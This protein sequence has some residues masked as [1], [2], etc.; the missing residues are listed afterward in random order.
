[1]FRIITSLPA[2]IIIAAIYVALV[3]IV[4]DMPGADEI[5]DVVEEVLDR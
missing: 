1:L 5:K 3:Y 4:P 2:L